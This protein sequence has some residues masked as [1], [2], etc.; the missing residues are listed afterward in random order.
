MPGPL[1]PPT[2]AVHEA[3]G[4][5]LAED[6]TPLGDLTSMLLPE[7]LRAVAA[8]VARGAGIVA[9]TACVTETFGRIDP[10]VELTWSAVDGDRVAA[11]TVIATVDG[12]LASI[13]TAERTALNFL[14]HLSGVA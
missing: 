6:L 5:A 14:C 7:D 3:V 10:S 11:G 9:G 8:F 4:R 2:T 1:E 12:R 13:L